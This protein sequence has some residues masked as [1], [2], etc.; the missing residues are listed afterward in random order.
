M[1]EAKVKGV[2]GMFNNIK[3][4]LSAVLLIM[5]LITIIAPITVY[6]ET[7]KIVLTD[8]EQEAI[9]KAMAKAMKSDSDSA[10]AVT[11]IGGKDE[12]TILQIEGGKLV[13][14]SEGFDKG[15]KKEVTQKMK[16]FV[17]EIQNST[18]SDDRQQ[19]IMNEIQET[20]GRVAAIMLPLIFEGTKGDLY[21]ALKV[22]GPFLDILNLV[23]GV[24]AVLL[25]ALVLFSTVM[26]MAYIGLPVWREANAGKEGNTGGKSKNPFGVTYEAISTVKEVEKNIVGGDYKNAYLLYF[27]RRALSYIILA[28]CIMYLIGGGISGIISFILN[29]ASGVTG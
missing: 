15:N 11:V 26:D 22:L 14:D 28:I 27:K 16:T 29:L 12:Y 2:K 25:I 5:I 13:V 8:S 17:K 21:T 6:A 18:I 9:Q 7:S 4:E 20:D 19:S 3:R 23:L 10:S 24:G 1:R